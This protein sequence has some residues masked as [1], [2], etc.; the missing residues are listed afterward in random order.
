LDGNTEGS[1]NTA[2]G[3]EALNHNGATA[4]GF[5]DENTAVGLEALFENTRGNGNTAT[6]LRAL[7]NNTTGN[8]NIAVGNLAGSNLL[9][10]SNDIYIG[11]P[12]LQVESGTIR[13]GAGGTHNQIFLAGINGTGVT[14]ADVLIA[15]DGQ[16][17]VP[18]SSARFKRD[19]RDMGGASQRLMELR[20]VTF[21]YKEDHTGTLQ[22]GLVAE[23]VARVYPELVTYGPDGRVLTVRYSELT[24]MLL[25]ELQKQNAQVHAEQKEIAELK[26]DRDRE[27]AER[28]AFEARLSAL[29]RSTEA[30]NEGGKLAAAFNK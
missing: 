26:A 17:G 7:R 19:I 24:G 5:G 27:R 20:P 15:A 25:N 11:N 29:E 14:G 10:G 6:G 2:V 16:L 28:S 4:T 30:R 18:L 9:D 21:R 3:A 22:Y 8:D 1:F 12:G 23:E 13:I